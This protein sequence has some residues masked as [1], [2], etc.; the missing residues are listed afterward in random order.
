MTTSEP[1]GTTEMSDIW[2][3]VNATLRIFGAGRYHEDIAKVTGLSPTHSHLKGE[4][5]RLKGERA[6]SDLW[7]YRSPLGSESK[8]DA[9]LMF[10]QGKVGPHKDFFHKLLREGATIDIFCGYR[11]NS[12]QGGFSLETG[13]LQVLADLRVRLEFSIIIT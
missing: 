13:S 7:N 9:H 4:S 3:K 10:I 5:T 8:L 2:C 11:S 1:R 6:K 12:D